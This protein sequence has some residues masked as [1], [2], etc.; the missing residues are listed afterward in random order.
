MPVDVPAKVADDAFDGLKEII[1]RIARPSSQNQ[2]R[3]EMSVR[4]G[5][6]QNFQRETVGGGAPWPPLRPRTVRERTRAGFPPTNPILQRTGAYMRSWTER[7]G[8]RQMEYNPNGWVMS[9]GSSH[10]NAPALEFGVRS[11]NLPARPVQYLDSQAERNI[12]SALD[13]VVTR[14]IASVPL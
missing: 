12:A 7:F 13:D 14:I 8:F 10:R 11:R 1:R 9:V 6:A 4:G 2:D 5:F 3:I